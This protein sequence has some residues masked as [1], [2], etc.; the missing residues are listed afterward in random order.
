M[1]KSLEA[2]TWREEEVFVKMQEFLGEAPVATDGVMYAYWNR[3]SPICLQAHID[4]SEGYS[5]KWKSDWQKGG[6]WDNKLQRWV[7]D[8]D[9]KDDE[10]EAQ[11]PFKLA[12]IRNIITNLNGVLGGDDRAGIMIMM[13]MET[14]CKKEKVPLPS[15][16][17]TNKEE[18]GSAGMKE[19]IKRE[20]KSLLA[21]VNLVVGLDRRGCGEYVYYTDPGKEVKHYV[22]TFGFIKSNGSYSDSKLLADDWGFLRLTLA[23]DIT[24]TIPRMK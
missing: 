1:D 10:E 19:F 18:T 12:R 21:P 24:T 4:V 8:D 22:E 5:V 6:H 9:G 23:S 15:L 17:L 16:L 14:L 7:N 2:F 13:L 11:K 3:K 20:K